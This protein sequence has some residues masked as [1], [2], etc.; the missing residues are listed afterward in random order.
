[1]NLK[2][3][4]KNIFVKK[5]GL[6]PC[7]DCLVRATC[8]FSKPCDRLEM[9]NEKLKD[10]F[11]KYE[12]CPDC[13]SENYT[14]GPSGG[15]SINIQCTGCEHWFNMALP[16]FVERIHLPGTMSGVDQSP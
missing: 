6:F 9:D 5:K 11:L 1:M 8:D 4:I 10:L 3:K 16:M 12:C 15:A 7:K 2:E 13:G 14:E